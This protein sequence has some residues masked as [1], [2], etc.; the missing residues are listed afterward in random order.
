MDTAYKTDRL[1]LALLIIILAITN[2]CNAATGMPYISTS[3]P[4]DH[5]I[6]LGSCS[7]NLPLN[8]PEAA[9]TALLKAESDYMIQQD[10][11]SLM[12]LWS[13]DGYIKDARHTPNN[14]TDD[15]IW[16]GTDAIRIRYLYHVFPGN[17]VY[18]EPTAISIMLTGNKAIITATTHINSEFSP[19]G[20][21]WQ[22]IKQDECW[23]IQ[24]LDFNL[25]Q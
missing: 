3:I 6:K 18:A 24:G 23:L 15:Q 22:L 20:D 14:L 16:Q 2:S 11:N 10:I 5:T 12:R 17:P 4:S 1:I 19:N 8:T 13:S 9:I 25:E 7:L 21:R